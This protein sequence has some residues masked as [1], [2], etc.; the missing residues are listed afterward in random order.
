MQSFWPGAMVATG[1]QRP[2]LCMA[3]ATFEVTIFQLVLS[4][5]FSESCFLRSPNVQAACSFFL[6]QL[7]VVG[8]LN[9]T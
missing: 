1:C 4:S 6:K 5:P 7:T 3:G 8:V 9:A 2:G